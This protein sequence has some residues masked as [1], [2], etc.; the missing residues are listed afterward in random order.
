MDLAVLPSPGQGELIIQA[1]EDRSTLVDWTSTFV[2]GYGIPEVMTSP[3]LALTESLATLLPFRHYLGSLNGKPVAT[4][5]LFLGAGVAGI[6]SV[7]TL[8]EARGRGVGTAMTLAPLRE[9]RD[10]GYR[11]GILQS[12][13][14]GYGVY[15]RLGFQRYCQMDHFYWSGGSSG[16]G[17]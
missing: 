7:S 4:S 9:A 14:M 8:P 15:E 12:S 2:R 10:M 6:Y 11:A 17:G 13:D 16:G 1:V 3:F 5:T